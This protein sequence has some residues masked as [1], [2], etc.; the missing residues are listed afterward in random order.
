MKSIQ[1]ITPTPP[2]LQ[3]LTNNYQISNLNLTQNQQ[4]KKEIKF[5]Y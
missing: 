5:Y 4:D 1:P 3:N 2:S